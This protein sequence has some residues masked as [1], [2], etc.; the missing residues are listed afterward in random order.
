MWYENEKVQIKLEKWIGT[1]KTQEVVEL[2]VGW[3]LEDEDEGRVALNFYYRS[4][5]F[6][7][8]STK[9]IQDFYYLDFDERDI[10]MLE[11]AKSDLVARIK[12]VDNDVRVKLEIRDMMKEAEK[13]SR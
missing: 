7:F 6:G 5:D 4:G 9:F 2:E 10:K 3:D 8:G 1:E 13:W 12:N 11:K